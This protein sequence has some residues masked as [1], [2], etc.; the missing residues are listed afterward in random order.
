MMDR[1]DPPK[2]S[3][4]SHRLQKSRTGRARKKGSEGRE[5]A[6]E[7]IQQSVHSFP[8]VRAANAFESQAFGNLSTRRRSP[9]R[10]NPPPRRGSA[11]RAECACSDH[12]TEPGRRAPRSC[13][14]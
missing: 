14:Q 9:A 12:Q 3:F 8:R 1:G 10:L 5:D 13:P 6:S 7:H 4:W 11:W 2:R